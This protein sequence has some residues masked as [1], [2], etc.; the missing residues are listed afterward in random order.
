MAVDDDPAVLAAVARDLRRQYGEAYRVVRADSGQRGLELVQ[1]AKLRGDDV[2]LFL[3][4]QRMPRM[5][6]L[7]FLAQAREMFPEARRVLLTAYAD[8]EASKRAMNETKLH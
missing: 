2:A 7:E 8:T 6:G 5:S 3:V 1:E 4:D